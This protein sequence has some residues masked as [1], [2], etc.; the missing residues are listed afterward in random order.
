VSR[1]ELKVFP[2]HQIDNQITHSLVPPHLCGAVQHTIV[3]LIKS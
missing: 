2:L 1:L 3:Q